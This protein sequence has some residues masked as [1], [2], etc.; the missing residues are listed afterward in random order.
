MEASLTI[1]SLREAGLRITPVRKLLVELLQSSEIPLSARELTSQTRANKTTIYREIA[2]L[3]SHGYLTEIDVGERAKR[4]ELSF[5]RHHH[6]LI[7]TACKSI[8]DIDLPHDFTR[9]EQLIATKNK[10][11]VSKHSLEFFGTCGNCRK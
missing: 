2:S 4:Y 6:H 3:L 5:R 8:A 7:C 1:Q 9:D 11:K 10:F